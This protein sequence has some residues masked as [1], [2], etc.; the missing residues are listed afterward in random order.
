MN[1]SLNISVANI[2]LET[3]DS[4]KITASEIERIDTVELI[5][6]IISHRDP[7]IGKMPIE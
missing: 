6:S 2:T 4:P 1:R 5:L 7:L 3:E